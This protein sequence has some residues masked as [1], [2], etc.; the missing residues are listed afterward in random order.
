MPNPL[1]FFMNLLSLHAQPKSLAADSWAT[2]K[3]VFGEGHAR[4]RMGTDRDKHS[5]SG[6][7]RMQRR[8]L[9]KIASASRRRNRAA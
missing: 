4:A 3:L 2:R 8:R 5:R 1:K 6:K 9:R 7:A